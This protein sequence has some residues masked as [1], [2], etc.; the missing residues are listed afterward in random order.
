MLCAL[1]ICQDITL[2]GPTKL[3][4]LWPFNKLDIG[5]DHLSTNS[6]Y[7]N[8][9]CKNFS[10]H[11]ALNQVVLS[12]NLLDKVILTKIFIQPTEK[13]R[14]VGL[15]KL[16]PMKNR[17][18]EKSRLES[19][20]FRSVSK[21]LYEVSVDSN[22]NKDIIPQQHLLYK[23]KD[24]K[25]YPLMDTSTSIPIVPWKFTKKQ[26]HIISDVSILGFLP[27]S[28]FSHRYK[29][30][31]DSPNMLEKVIRLLY[32]L[33]EIL[34]FTSKITRPDVHACISYIITR[35]KLPTNYHK[36]GHLNGDV[37]FVKKIQLFVLSSVED[38]CMHLELLFSKY[39]K[40]LLY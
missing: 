1:N 38:Q 32:R 34:L 9:S 21:P 2:Y 11:S 40:H 6:V 25:N 37:L 31:T 20:R 23:N 19:K 14:S 3:N 5:N 8:H 10:F 13:P 7:D 36:E 22:S 35:M 4:S 24:K 29:L 27:H 39:T 16:I 18:K 12:T 33:I 28:R 15:H 30:N 26:P 17:N